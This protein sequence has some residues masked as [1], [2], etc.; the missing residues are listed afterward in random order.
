M[1]DTSD[2]LDLPVLTGEDSSKVVTLLP[3]GGGQPLLGMRIREP[4]D[5]GIP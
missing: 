4:L 5:G 3:N 1:P 2:G